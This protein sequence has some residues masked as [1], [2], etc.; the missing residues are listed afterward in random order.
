MLLLNLET[1]GRDYHRA[2]MLTSKKVLGPLGL[3]CLL[4]ST[5]TIQGGAVA[6]ILSAKCTGIWSCLFL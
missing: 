6:G 4:A 5:E 3:D 2:D 1:Q